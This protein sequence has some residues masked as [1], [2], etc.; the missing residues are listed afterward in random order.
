M[1]QAST[2]GVA[3]ITKLKSPPRYN[4]VLLNDETTPQ[5][6][7]VNVLQAIFNKSVDEAKLV[8]L[9][10]HEK[11]RGIAGTYSYE[12][13]EQKSVETITDA[14]RNEFPLDVT[15]EKVE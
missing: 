15:I 1:T 9:E 2:Q 6:F 5:D 13:A 14:R 8:M 12:V 10:V 7:V 4:V 3:D 11:G